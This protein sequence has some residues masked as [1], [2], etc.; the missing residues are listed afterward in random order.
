[1]LW[2]SIRCCDS[3][4]LYENSIDNLVLQNH[5]VLT[6]HESSMKLAIHNPL[7]WVLNNL[8]SPF[9]IIL[10]LKEF[11]LIICS[12]C[13]TYQPS[14]DTMAFLPSYGCVLH[15]HCIAVW[16]ALPL[17]DVEQM[18]TESATCKFVR[19]SEVKLACKSPHLFCCNPTQLT[20]HCHQSFCSK[21]NGYFINTAWMCH[22]IGICA[23]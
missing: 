10:I 1:M 5:Q 9:S 21:C 19:L 13:E 23:D 3:I 4:L 2:Q 7:H 6:H 17:H 20:Y 12:L 22:E 18:I 15:Y 14:I 8:A 11:L 16:F